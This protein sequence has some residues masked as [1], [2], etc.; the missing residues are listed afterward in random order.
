MLVLRRSRSL[1]S[2]TATTAA[3]DSRGRTRD[4][5]ARAKDP[6]WDGFGDPYDQISP[7][8]IESLQ[9]QP[10]FVMHCAF[11]IPDGMMVGEIW[12]SADEES[13]RRSRRPSGRTS[14][15]AP[16]S[17]GKQSNFTTWWCVSEFGS[18]RQT[19]CCL[20]KGYLPRGG[21][22]EQRRSAVVCVGNA[23]VRTSVGEGCSNVIEATSPRNMLARLI[24]R[25]RVPSRRT[26]WGDAYSCVSP[27]LPFV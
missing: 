27:P 15:P 24:S 7:P 22:E 26:N 20:L 18:L 25:C 23:A 3:D 19:L 17:S 11:A 16:R 4:G 1:I 2:A 12:E 21:A 9:K 6:S 5:S 10:G 14:H 13:K 8:L